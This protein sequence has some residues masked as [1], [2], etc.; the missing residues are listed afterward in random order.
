MAGGPIV[1]VSAFPVTAG[2]AFPMIY[3]GAGTTE[4]RTEMLGIADATEVTADAVLWH[5][6]FH[7]PEVLP[8]GT[9]KLQIRTRANATTGVI[10]LNIQWVSV[11][12]AQ[13]PDDATMNDEG[14]VDIT[15]SATADQYKNTL[16]TMDADTVVAGEII[17]MNIE[18]DDTPAH[19]IAAD[20]GCLFSIIWE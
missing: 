15:T 19:T 12:E 2:D 16:M 4:D 18:V 7:T 20:T 14:S 17:H 8:T 10:G 3:Q 11:S 5:L 9:A 13:S 1:P 6:V